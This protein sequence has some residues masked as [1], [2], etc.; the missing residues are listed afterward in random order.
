EVAATHSTVDMVISAMTGTMGLIPTVAA[1]NAGKSIGLANKEVLVSGGALVMELARQKNIPIIPIDSEHSALF[2]C[3]QSN[4]TKAV[5]RLILTASGGPFRTFSQEQLQ[6]VTV[7]QA[8][9]H[10]NWNMGPKVTIDSSTLMNKG[11]EMIEA[12]WL[13]GIPVNQIEVV[14]HPQ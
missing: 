10:P 7:E 13:F 6:R 11:L 1:I 9:K 8:L 5:K 2:Q 4:S 14:I 3:L 12:Y